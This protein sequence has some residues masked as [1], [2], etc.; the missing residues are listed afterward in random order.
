MNAHRPTTMPRPHVNTASGLDIRYC[1]S[2]AA[3]AMQA[4]MQ[5]MPLALAVRE[6]M[7][8]RGLADYGTL[9]MP[10]LDVGCGDGLFWEVFAKELKG[11]EARHL[12]GLVGIDINRAELD[13][14]SVRLSPVGGEVRSVDI[15]DKAAGE[16]LRGRFKTIIANCSLEHVPK[17]EHAIHNIS[18]YLAP[19]GELF[20]ILPTPSWTD[21]LSTKKFL[22]RFSAR[23]AGTFAGAFD[24][25]YQHH[26]LY[27]WYVWEHLLH[28]FGFDTEIKGLGSREANRIT[29]R[30]YP[31][32]VASFLYKGLF[33]HYPTRFTASFKQRYMKK[34]GK[35]LEEIEQGTVVHDD[36]EHPEV[37][38]Y[39]VRCT[40]RSD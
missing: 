11:G 15:S 22:A 24:G 20:M 8:M 3:G 29:E 18:S 7:R 12:E 33:D 19:G 39:L 23:L 5:Y 28:G 35:F 40:V 2:D 9:E 34:L 10:M 6:L 25:F 37:I 32:A 38:E 13:L 26:H 36:L 16:E 4:L 1:K 17:L 14:A 30:W 27:P 31:P 21:T